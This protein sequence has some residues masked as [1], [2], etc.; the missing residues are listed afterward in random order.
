MVF[1]RARMDYKQLE[2]VHMGWVLWLAYLLVPPRA[3]ALP[4]SCLCAA[5]ECALCAHARPTPPANAPAFLRCAS[6]ESTE[7]Q[8]PPAQLG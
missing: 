2:L 3:P 8:V 7:K 6:C 5:Y 1:S 4:D